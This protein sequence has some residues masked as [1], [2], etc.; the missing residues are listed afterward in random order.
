MSELT[1]ISKA[2]SVNLSLISYNS[3]VIVSTADI[4]DSLSDEMVQLDGH[5]FVSEAACSELAECV[6]APNENFSFLI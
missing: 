2:P 6:I 4:D 5:I 3:T 1:L